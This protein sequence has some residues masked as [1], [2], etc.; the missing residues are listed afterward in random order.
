MLMGRGPLGKIVML[1]FLLFNAAMLC[2][3]GIA[4]GIKE[5]PSEKIRAEVWE[6]IV[7]M[8]KE[9]KDDRKLSD[10]DIADIDQAVDE[11]MKVVVFAQ[12]KG[13][14]GVLALWALGA[15]ILGVFA[16]LTRPQPI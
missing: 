6:K 12:E 11:I 8:G 15:G 5:T 10:Q 2:L 1:V 16:Y 14:T 3:A 9:T 7:E 13:L 4:Y